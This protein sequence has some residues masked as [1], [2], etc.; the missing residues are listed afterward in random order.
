MAAVEFEI[1]VAGPVPAGVLEELE[2]IEVISQAVDTVLRGPCAGPGRAGRHHQPAAELGRRTARCSTTMSP[3][4]HHRLRQG[5]DSAADRCLRSGPRHR[6]LH[7]AGHRLRRRVVTRGT[8]RS[9]QVPG[10]SAL[11]QNQPL[12]LTRSVRTQPHDRS[13]LMSTGTAD[14]AA[15]A[16]AGSATGQ[17]WTARAAFAAIAAA[18]VVLVASE[19]PI[20]LTLL[21]V[22]LLGTVAVLVGGFWFIAKRGV[23]RWV[24][25]VLAVLAVLLVVVIFFR[26]GVV[27]V[28]LVSLLLLLLGGAAARH[29]LRHTPEPWMP[30]NAPVPAAHPFIVMNPRSG[31][32]KVVRFDLAAK[33]KALGAEVAVLEGPG[34]VDVA[35]LV[36]DAVDRGADLLGVAGGDGTQA[37]VAGIAADHDIPLLVISAGTRNHFA[38]DLGLDRDD[39]STCLQALADGEEVRVDLGYI[40]DRPF[41]NNASFGAYA[42]IVQS[43]EY[44][45]NKERTILSMLP[46]L[47]GKQKGAD[48]GVRAVTTTGPTT[49]QDM[50]AVLISNNPYGSGRLLDMGRRYRLD[51]GVLGVIAGRLGSTAEAVGLLR[52]QQFRSVNALTAV[53]EVVVQ[54]TDATIPVGI[55]GEAVTVDTPVHC[56]IRPRALRVR[57]PRNR[58]GVPPPLPRIDWKRL[59]QIAFGR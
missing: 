7:R 34:Y 42:Q 59:W 27:A 14:P 18:V 20:G 22:G 45:D 25:L 53:G 47:L 5:H 9:G 11:F 10:L 36:R 39:P 24:G 43:P 1:R 50:Q 15:A 13:N 38:L 41:V 31:G 8:H 35:A 26:A 49:L 19:G 32:G 12:D 58:P 17:R 46:D 52:R 56:T 6:R 55:D 23:L 40:A 57:L 3:G 30:T 28:A 4:V 16:H 44:R 37:L 21:G 51:E 48:L 54:S 2:N 29:A 33:A